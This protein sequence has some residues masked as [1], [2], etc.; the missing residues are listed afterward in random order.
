MLKLK[1][2]SGAASAWAANL[3]NGTYVDPKSNFIEVPQLPTNGVQQAGTVG[4][5]DV[6]KDLAK[7][8][9]TASEQRKFDNNVGS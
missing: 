4:I 2:G 7:V 3:D 8:M 6:N 9:M 1:G 5:N